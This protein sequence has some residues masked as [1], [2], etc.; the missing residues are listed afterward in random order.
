MKIVWLAVNSSYSHSSLALPALH[1]VVQD[2]VEADW[3]LVQVTIKDEVAAVVARIA[4]HEPDVVAASVYLFNRVRVLE[5]LRRVK[6]LF[7]DCRIILGG[8]EFLG[9]NAS[10]LQSEPGIDLVLR[11][12]GELSFATWLS[13]VGQPAAWTE[14]PGLCWRDSVGKFHDN[15]VA[16]AGGDLAALP[17]PGE[18]VFFDWS[19]PFV[20]LETSRGCASTCSYCTSCSTGPVR[21]LAWDRVVA[22]L[23]Q[24]RSRGICEVRILD[25]TFNANP[26]RCV[27]LLRHF[28]EVCDDM[29]FHLEINP[30]FLVPAV[31]AELEKAVPGHLHLEAGLQTTCVAALDAV[32]RRSDPARVWAGV[33]YLCG[34]KNVETHVDLLAGLPQLTLEYLYRDLTDLTK[35]G[36]NEIQ[37]ETL[38][39]LPGTP[40]LQE[41]ASLG[42]VFASD[43]PYEVLRTPHMSAGDLETA[44]M[45]SKLVDCFYN[46]PALRD[47]V[48]TAVVANDAF[49]PDFLAYLRHVGA[50]ANPL[51]LQNRFRVFHDFLVDRDSDARRL[52]EYH[53]FMAGLSPAH[54]I[55]DAQIWKTDLPSGVRL[56]E[57]DGTSPANA[58]RMWHLCQETDQYWFVYDR[59]SAGR[60]PVAVFTAPV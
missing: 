2:R 17:F 12:E 60:S 53:W 10:F 1:M 54:G 40:L 52:L 48:R 49:Y 24:V 47:V 41:T 23:Q 57:G 15:G 14:I 58:G 50:L 56:L 3:E 55:C 29:R 16:C 4:V 37:L 35:V 25:R 13:V 19:N 27:R 8:P 44:R 18:S 46:Q 21:Q 36:P 34:C 28:R 7:P 26:L 38:K 11:G 22:D 9:D 5:I 42:I 59:R 32:R 43:P 33:T 20:Q 6:C 51:S 39:I 45:L 30:E 31:R